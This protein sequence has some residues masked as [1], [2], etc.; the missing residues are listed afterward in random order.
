MT[1]RTAFSFGVDVAGLDRLVLIHKVSLIMPLPIVVSGAPAAVPGVEAGHAPDVVRRRL[2]GS[3]ELLR[4]ASRSSPEPFL[5]DLS[6]VHSCRPEQV[7]GVAGRS[8]GRDRRPRPR[9]T[10]RLEG[11]RSHSAHGH[12][13]AAEAAAARLGVQHRRHLRRRA[14]ASTRRS[15]SSAT[16]TSTRTAPSGD[17]HGRLVC[18]QD[19]RSVAGRWR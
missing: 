16:T 14:T 15:S 4:A 9:R 1:I 13:L 8:A 7:Q 2:P 12:D 11:R 10:V 5:Q 17:G 18:R 3:V 19:R 6:G